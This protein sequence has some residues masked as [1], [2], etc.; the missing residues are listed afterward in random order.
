MLLEELGTML[1]TLGHGTLGE[2]LFI[3]QLPDEPDACIALRGY[4]G[5]EPMWTHSGALPAFERQRFQLTARAFTVGDAMTAAAAAWRSLLVIRNQAVGGGFYLAVQP[6]QSP[7][8][9]ERDE[10]NR[11]I[12]AAN[13]EAWRETT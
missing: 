3:Y 11:W 2:T 5:R 7:F 1:Q 12:A 13:F 9:V 4:E 10:N 8:I 6:L